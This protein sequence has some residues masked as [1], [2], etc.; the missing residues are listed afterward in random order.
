MRTHTIGIWTEL[1]WDLLL[2]MRYGVFS[3]TTLLVERSGAIGSPSS[4][5]CT[6]VRTRSGSRGYG[7]DFGVVGMLWALARESFGMYDDCRII[8]CDENDAF[9]NCPFSSIKENTG[10]YR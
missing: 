7:C 10:E 9:L 2:L 5:G 6:S 8:P 4:C 1:V 3:V